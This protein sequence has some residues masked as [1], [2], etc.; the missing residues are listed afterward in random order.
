MNPP[1]FNLL[2]V[3]FPPCFVFAQFALDASFELLRLSALDLS[4]WFM[5][6]SSLSLHGF[7][8]TLIGK[9]PSLTLPSY[10]YLPLVCFTSPPMCV[11]KMLYDQGQPWPIAG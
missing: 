8:V 1:A 3:S 5:S 6:F 2:Q 9:V 10:S 11:R 4:H 7:I